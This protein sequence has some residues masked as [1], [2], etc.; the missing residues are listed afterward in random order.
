MGLDIRVCT[1]AEFVKSRI[2]TDEDYELTH[3]FNIKECSQTVKEPGM[4][5]CETD[6]RIW[7]A[8]Y[9]FYN[10]MRRELAHLIGSDVNTIWANPK[11]DIPFIEL[12][13]HSDCEARFDT[14]ACKELDK[15]FKEWETL[16]HFGS[17]DF[18]AFYKSLSQAFETA[19]NN[20]GCI[21]FS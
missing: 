18:V 21:I 16:S 8:P 7:S 11:Q 3:L 12:I 19:A 14:E 2:E 15:D 6:K 5:R 20:N 17:T 10:E 13:N 4:Y 1:N 9:R